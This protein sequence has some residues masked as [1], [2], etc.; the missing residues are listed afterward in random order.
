MAYKLRASRWVPGLRNYV[1]YNFVLPT[2]SGKLAGLGQG[3]AGISG[4]T[5]ALLGAGAA[6]V[7]YFF[8]RKK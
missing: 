7:W 6:A 1:D 5:L 4:T 2:S 3:V 8:I